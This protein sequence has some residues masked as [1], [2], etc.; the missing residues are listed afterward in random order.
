MKMTMH[1]DEG[2]LE[3]VMKL[4]A[5]KSKTEAIDFALREA[6]RKSK[7]LKFVADG[8]V[9]GDEWS[10]SVDPDYNIVALRAAEKPNRY[11][12]KRGSR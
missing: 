10:K 11:R 2:L 6:E 1:I 9:A 5:F 8:K 4:G 3:R 7:I 12:V